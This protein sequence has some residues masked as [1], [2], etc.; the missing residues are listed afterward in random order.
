MNSRSQTRG[1][2]KR[3]LLC[4]AVVSLAL[5]VV[6]PATATAREDFVGQAIREEPHVQVTEVD[7]VRLF[8]ASESVSAEPGE[9]SP[10]AL[11]STSSGSGYK[12]R[13]E[14]ALSA[15]RGAAKWVRH[16]HAFTKRLSGSGP[17]EAEAHAVLIEGDSY[18]DE[19][20]FSGYTDSCAAV[21]EVNATAKTCAS[22]KFSTSPGEKWLAISGQYYDHGNDGS[23][24]ETVYGRLDFVWTAPS[25]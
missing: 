16:Y 20:V 22:S 18:E 7:D 11:G 23:L 24:D 4:V 5:P 25:S 13:F 3:F 1:W 17:Y 15:N 9:G 12:V 6:I 19:Q 21:V 10:L 2:P 14:N 8:I